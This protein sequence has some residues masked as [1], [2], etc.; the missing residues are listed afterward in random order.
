MVRLRSM[1]FKVNI[2]LL[3]MY[4]YVKYFK[5]LDKGEEVYGNCWLFLGIRYVINLL[6]VNI[7]FCDLFFFVVFNNVNWF[8]WCLKIMNIF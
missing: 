2:R 1:L 4:L 7:K 6:I 3:I 8:Y 5:K